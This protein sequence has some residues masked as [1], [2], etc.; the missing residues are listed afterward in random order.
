M[1][2]SNRFSFTHIFVAQLSEPVVGAS[3]TLQPPPFILD[4]LMVDV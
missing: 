3:N 4:R 1:L 2:P